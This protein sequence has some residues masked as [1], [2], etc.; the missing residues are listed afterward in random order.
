MGIACFAL[1]EPLFW[2][3]VPRMGLIC[4]GFW[5]W[6]PR[7]LLCVL[8]IDRVMSFGIW[9]EGR[10]GRFEVG[11]DPMGRTSDDI[12]Y[13]P[14]IR[15]VQDP[16][17]LLLD[18]IQKWKGSPTD[19]ELHLR[20]LLSGAPGPGSGS[21]KIMR[22][23]A[24]ALLKALGVCLLLESRRDKTSHRHRKGFVLEGGFGGFGSG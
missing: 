13:S 2:V 14:A 15:W 11:P 23:Q 17:D 24:E 21:G 3:T 20:S 22:L 4:A 9:L 19:I 1:N 10:A 18:A 8:G 6:N 12:M 5:A 7:L 16:E